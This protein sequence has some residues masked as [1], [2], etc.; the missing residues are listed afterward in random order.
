MTTRQ[1]ITKSGDTFEWE[2][3][4]EVAAVKKLHETITNNKQTMP[5]EI[6]ELP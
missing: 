3:T 1:Y 4:P 2:E 5:V 6:T